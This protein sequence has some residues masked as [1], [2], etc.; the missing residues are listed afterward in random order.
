[1]LIQAPLDL[2]GENSVSPSVRR[3][4]CGKVKLPLYVIPPIRSTQKAKPFLQIKLNMCLN[5]C[6]EV[7]CVKTFSKKVAGKSFM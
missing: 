6:C 4:H 2:G 3:L 7:F 1:M 5:V